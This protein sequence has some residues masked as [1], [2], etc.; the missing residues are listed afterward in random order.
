MKLFWKIISN[1]YSE[2]VIGGLEMSPP[3]WLF[4]QPKKTLPCLYR[5]TVLVDVNFTDKEKELIQRAVKD[6]HYF[7]NGM[8]E[9]TL[10]FDLNP[11]DYDRIRNNSVLL[12][13]G[14]GHPSIVASDE[15]L[16]STT[17]GLC[18]YMDNKTKRLYLVTERLPNPTVFRTTTVHEFGHFI[19]M[20]HT[21]MPSIMHK[22][23]NNVLYPTHKD[24]KELSEV[25]GEWPGYFRYF[26]Q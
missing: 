4:H 19:G 16:Q 11:Y 1:I 20:G 14:P 24:A 12:K 22:H 3:S 25:W 5:D 2:L 10:V 23:N 13:V 9:L 7:C 15:K 6:L 26:K 17:L 18:E 21:E 8:V